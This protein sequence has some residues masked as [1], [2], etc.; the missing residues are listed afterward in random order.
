M[1]LKIKCQFDYHADIYNQMSKK[2][3]KKGLVAEIGFGFVK[4]A[5]SIQ[6]LAQ[7]SLCLCKWN[8]HSY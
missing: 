8:R 3:K 4:Q 2:K 6:S 1:P 5:Y 7:K